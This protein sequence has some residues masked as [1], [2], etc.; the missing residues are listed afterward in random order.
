MSVLVKKTVEIENY[1]D[2]N[3]TQIASILAKHYKSIK[4][5]DEFSDKPVGMIIGQDP[6]AG[7]MIVPSKQILYLRSVKGKISGHLTILVVMMRKN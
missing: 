6:E 4:S 1:T 2:R 3:F 7:T 5:E